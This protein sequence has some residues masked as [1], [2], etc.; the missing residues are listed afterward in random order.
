VVE[1][2][3]R[4]NPLEALEGASATACFGRDHDQPGSSDHLAAVVSHLA[5]G[6]RIHIARIV[7]NDEDLAAILSR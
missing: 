1:L 3:E 2:E 4:L 5:V 6:D 7:G